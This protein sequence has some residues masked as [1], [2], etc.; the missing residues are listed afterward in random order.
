MLQ[1][2]TNIELCSKISKSSNLTSFEL[3]SPSKELTKK[4]KGEILIIC[5]SSRRKP[6]LKIGKSRLTKTLRLH[7]I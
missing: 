1:N 4:T 2:L 7:S 6:L 5:T 3:E